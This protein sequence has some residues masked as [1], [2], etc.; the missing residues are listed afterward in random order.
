MNTTYETEVTC[1]IT[2]E[3]QEMDC[4]FERTW[5]DIKHNNL[6]GTYVEDD[7]ARNITINLGARASVSV[8]D[9][10]RSWREQVYEAVDE[11]M[12]RNRPE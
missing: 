2:I 8:D 12:G 10:P 9:L 6:L 7:E 11:W 5:K 3:D 1:Q 4:Y